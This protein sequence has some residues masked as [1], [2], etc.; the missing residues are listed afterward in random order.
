M[1]SS[2]SKGF[3]L[4]SIPPV[5]VNLASLC[6]KLIPEAEIW[7]KLIS[8]N[9]KRYLFIFHILKKKRNLFGPISLVLA[10]C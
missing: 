6:A 5:L 9:K 3:E 2:I 1:V 4:A 10:A 8:K 7:L